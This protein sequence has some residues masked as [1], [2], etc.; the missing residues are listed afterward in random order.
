M[1]RLADLLLRP[2]QNLLAGL[3]LLV[4]GIAAHLYAQRYG[5]GTL[6]RMGPGFFPQIVSLGIA[7]LGA[8][9][10]VM[11]DDA[12][13]ERLPLRW[14][15]VRSAACVLGALVA[16]ALLIRPAGVVI[17][18]GLAALIGSLV[19]PSARLWA[20]LAMAAFVGALCATVFVGLLNMP[21]RLWGTLL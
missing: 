2:R 15:E 18:S 12:D 1:R 19:D 16:F 13:R 14:S 4:L 5:F 3:A 10:L 7:G 8:L 6:R 17:A 11:P 9:L 21:L 20:R